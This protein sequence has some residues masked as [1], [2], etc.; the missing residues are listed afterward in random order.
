MPSNFNFETQREQSA[1]KTE[2]VTKY[3]NAW[4]NVLKQNNERLAYIDLFSGP[5]LYQDGT[6]STPIIILEKMVSDIYMKDHIVT[7]FNEKDPELYNKLVKNT[8]NVD[9]IEGLKYSP[10]ITNN[11]IDYNTPEWFAKRSLIPS[12]SF[13]DPAGY[14][15]LSLE[16]MKALGKDHG[17]D[18]IFFFNFNEINRGI[19]NYKVEEHMK[20]LFGQENYLTL[21]KKI[22]KSPSDREAIIINEMAIALQKAGLKYVLPFKFKLE[23]KNRTSHYLIFASKKFLGYRIMKEIMHKAGEKDYEGVG[24]FEFIPSC[25]K[26]KGIQL[27]IIDL[28]NSSLEDLE[29]RLLKEYKGK[30]GTLEKLYEIDGINN[31]FLIKHYRDIILKLEEEGKIWCNPPSEERR[32]YKGRRS[33][34]E[35]K[36]KIEF[37]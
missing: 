25:D 36:V 22:N 34:N 11:I 23:G 4:V 12:F 3:F 28:F 17:S 26:E 14:A 20:Q 31:K 2:I 1:V 35:K 15:G 18:L 10:N 9:G 33:L 21:L 13:I 19:T 30:E 5:G 6:K 16:L 29:T 32:M 37:L 8:K 27:S 24:K 7:L